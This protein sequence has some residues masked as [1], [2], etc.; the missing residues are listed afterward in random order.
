MGAVVITIPALDIQ[1]NL[2][3]QSQETGI[4][5]PDIV[6]IKVMRYVSKEV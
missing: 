5:Y 3:A 2:Q 6:L 1:C 4:K